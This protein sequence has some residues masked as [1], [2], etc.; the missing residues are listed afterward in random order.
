MGIYGF[1]GCLWMSMRV[2]GFLKSR[3]FK[4]AILNSLNFTVTPEKITKYPIQS[5][6]PAQ[7]T[8]NS[9]RY[10]KAQK[11]KFLKLHDFFKL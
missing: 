11:E 8:Q 10:S 3:T 1:H 2:N 9:L 6:L 5:K 4:A 7:K